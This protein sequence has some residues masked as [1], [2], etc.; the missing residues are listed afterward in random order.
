M[1]PGHG[2]HKQIRSVGCRREIRRRVQLLDAFAGRFR[3]PKP[4]WLPALSPIADAATTLC[5]PCRLHARQ[6]CVVWPRR[7]TLAPQLNMLAYHFLRCRWLPR[8]VVCTRDIL[9]VSHLFLP[10]IFGFYAGIGTSWELSFGH[11]GFSAP[12]FSFLGIS[13]VAIYHSS[14]YCITHIIIGNQSFSCRPGKMYLYID[15]TAQKDKGRL[16]A[17]I[18]SF[19]R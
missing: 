1:A 6:A 17:V 7:R 2:P 8:N 3:G 11:L 5:R 13:R 12:T 4:V 14:K 18:S 10:F 16:E 9:R 15:Y 19:P